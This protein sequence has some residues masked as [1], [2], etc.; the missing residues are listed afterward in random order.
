[1]SAPAITIR[2]RQFSNGS[3]APHSPIPRQA[4]R[5]SSSPLTKPPSAK[6][7]PTGSLRRALSTFRPN[8]RTIPAAGYISRSMAAT[9]RGRPSATPFIKESG[10]ARYADTNRLVI[11]FPQIAASVVNPGGCW[12][13]WGYSDID[14]LSKDAPQIQAVWD[15]A[16]RL[17]MQP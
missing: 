1:M 14:Y 11:L 10:F 12:D 15:M 7:V 5:G 8:A 2:R 13:W 17:V 16:G 9:R 4:R 6:A 3:M